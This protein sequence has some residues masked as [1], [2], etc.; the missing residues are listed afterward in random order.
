MV[1]TF[2]IGEALDRQTAED[3]EAF[4]GRWLSYMRARVGTFEWRCQRYHGVHEKLLQLGLTDDAT[5]VDVGS[6]NCEFGRY[7]YAVAGFRGRYQA[8]DAVLDGTDLERWSPALP[9]DF[10]VAIEVIEHLADPARLVRAMTRWA[11]GGVV[12]TTPNPDVVDVLGMDRT[13][14]TAVPVELLNDWGFQVA[15]RNYFGRA[16]DSLLAWRATAAR[17]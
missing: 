9:T 8:V 6:G 5:V 1:G 3:R 13:H 15:P 7:L 4:R 17:S 16:S 14:R 11:R 12:L 10:L 2:D